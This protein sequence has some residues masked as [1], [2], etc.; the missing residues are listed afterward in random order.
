MR[1]QDKFL[2]ITAFGAVT[3]AHLDAFEALVGRFSEGMGRQDTPLVNEKLTAIY[4]DFTPTRM[5]KFQQQSFALRICLLA[6]LFFIE[7]SAERSAKIEQ[8]IA[9]YEVFNSGKNK[10]HI[11]E[12]V[13]PTGLEPVTSPL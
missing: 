6:Q 5:Q 2:V 4:A 13:G 1:N 10:E 8:A 9:Q 12:M 7:T 11:N 3:L